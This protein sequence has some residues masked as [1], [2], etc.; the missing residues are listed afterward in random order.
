MALNTLDELLAA[1]DRVGAEKPRSATIPGMG[2]VFIREITIGE[3]DAQ[4]ADTEAKDKRA[5]ARGACRLLA[6]AKGERLMDPDNKQHV[7]K[8]AKMPLRV[9]KA[10]NAAADLDKAADEGN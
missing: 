10:I 7:D 3:I 9:L 1:M 8:M 5:I 6:N 4:M 2:Q